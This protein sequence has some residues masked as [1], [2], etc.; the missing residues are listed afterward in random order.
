M[1]LDTP[2]LKRLQELEDQLSSLQQERDQLKPRIEAEQ[3]QAI[4][5]VQPPC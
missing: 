4:Q 1:T 5:N 2:S 3:I